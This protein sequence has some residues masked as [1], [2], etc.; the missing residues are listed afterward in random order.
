MGEARRGPER[1]P[2]GCPGSLSRRVRA[3]LTSGYVQRAYR[4]STRVLGAVL[5]LLGAALVVVTLA[6]GGGPIAL[7]VVMGLGLAVFGAG[8]VLLTAG[9][10]DDGGS[11]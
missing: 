2:D 5:F 9:P 10:R 1:R 6:R 8:R 11:P 7:G 3:G 4:H